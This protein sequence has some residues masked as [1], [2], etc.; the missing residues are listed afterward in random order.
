MS[1]AAVAHGT[2]QQER[3]E[4][5]GSGGLPIRGEVRLVRPARLGQPK[6]RQRNDVKEGC[7]PNA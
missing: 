4:L 3:F 1:D 2:I 5:T 7:E 6:P